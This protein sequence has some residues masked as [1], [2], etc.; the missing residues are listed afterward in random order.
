[1]RKLLVLFAVLAL[2]AGG[3]WY[4]SPYW[5]LD[6]LRDAA[7]AGDVEGLEDHV[8]FPALRE[9]LKEQ[10]QANMDEAIR[11]QGGADEPLGQLGAMMARGMVDPLVDRMVTPEGVAG[12]VALGNG[13]APALGSA[14]GAGGLAKAPPP[15]GET[16]APQAGEEVDWDIK[17]EGLGRFTVTPELPEGQPA[18]SL[19]FERRGLGWKMTGIN[20]PDPGL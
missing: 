6:G 17:R 2:L 3:W 20:L 19:V 12:M 1:M 4:A 8:D 5:A 14:R 18:P 10:V 9:D 16:V 11:S 15:P 7:L 13:A